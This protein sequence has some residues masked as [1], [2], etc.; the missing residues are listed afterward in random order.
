MRSPLKID[1]IDLKTQ[2]T[3]PSSVDV[4]SELPLLRNLI[5]LI[6]CRFDAAN[7]KMKVGRD[8]DDAKSGSRSTTVTWCLEKYFEGEVS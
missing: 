1:G 8:D 7:L 3:L 6:G 2:M 4:I 5:V